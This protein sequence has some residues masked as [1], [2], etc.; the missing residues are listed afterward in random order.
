LDQ[1][2]YTAETRNHE[3][4]DLEMVKLL[5]KVCTFYEERHVIMDCPFVLF[6]IIASIAK[7]VKLQN[8]ARVLMDQPQEQE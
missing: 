6:H 7:H 1:T 3:S 5:S 2:K 4:M 8:V